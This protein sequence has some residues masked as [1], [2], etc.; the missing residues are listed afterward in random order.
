[1]ADWRLHLLWN[2]LLSSVT[3]PS[4]LWTWLLW[5]LCPPGAQSS[6]VWL[7]FVS[8]RIQW[9]GTR[10]VWK[11]S[12][13]G[14]QKSRPD[15]YGP[16]RQSADVKEVTTPEQPCA[17]SLDGYNICLALSTQYMIL[18]YS[19]GASQDLFPYDCEERKPIVKRIGREEF[20]LAAPGGLGELNDQKWHWSVRADRLSIRILI[21]ACAS[22]RL[23]FSLLKH[24]RQKWYLE[25]LHWT[26]SVRSVTE[27]LDII[28]ITVITFMV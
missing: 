10:S 13:F 28:V 4:L 3:Q 15:L 21:Q 14:T 16:R 11:C 19:T 9:Q 24:F 17:L 20:L 12:G 22:M 27:Y 6:K 8:T 23:F 26:F 5:S 7:R 25:D 18:N 1:M 2:V